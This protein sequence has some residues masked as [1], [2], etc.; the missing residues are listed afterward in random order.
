MADV[1][2]AFLTYY[3]QYDR[4]SAENAFAKLNSEFRFFTA[5]NTAPFDAEIRMKEE[6]IAVRL[7]FCEGYVAPE[8]MTVIGFFFEHFSYSKN[9]VWTT[10][11]QNI[12]L[13]FIYGLDEFR[14]YGGRIV[15]HISKSGVRK[16][17]DLLTEGISD[18]L[19]LKL[20][21]RFKM[22]EVCKWTEF[23]EQMNTELLA[24]TENER[25]DKIISMDVPVAENAYEND[26]RAAGVFAESAADGLALSVNNLGRVD[27]EYISKIT[28]ESLKDVLS[29]LSGAVYQNPASWGECFYKGWETADMY[30]SGNILEKLRTAKA[31]NAKYKG[32]FRDN[33]KALKRVLPPKISADDIYITLGSPWVPPD[34]IDDFILYLLGAPIS[35]YSRKKKKH[36]TEYDAEKALWKIPYKAE[37]KGQ[38]KSVST[39]GTERM[40][41]LFILE[42]TLNMR[43]VLVFDE[44]ESTESKSG[45]KR[46]I[47]KHETMLAAEK[48]QIMMKEFSN[49][50]WQDA[51]R[52]AR[53][54]DI[55]D[56]TFG[57]CVV[58]RYDGSFL[59]F[60]EM[61]ACNT[62]YDYQK[63]AVAR[64]MFSKNTLLAH[65][66]GAGKTYVMIAAG[67]E[68][69]RIGI[70]KKNMYVVPNSILG[71][72]K[73]IFKRL[74]PRA[75]VFCVEPDLFTPAKRDKTLL[76]MRDEDF[77]AILIAYSCFDRIPTFKQACDSNFT[78]CF[79]D[80]KINT[81]F[82]DEAH[83][84]KNL[85]FKTKITNVLGI[86]SAG[87]EKC[88]AM[89]DKVLTVQK[90]NHGRGV[91]FATGTPITNSLTDIYTMQTYL[92][93][94]ALARFGLQSFDS[95]VGMFAE[96]T[97]EAEIG[98]DTSSFRMATRFSKFHNLPELAMLI[99][100]FADF[101]SVDKQNE[102]PD[103]AGYTDD[104]VSKTKEMKAYLE[105]IS[106]RADAIRAHL[107]DS[108]T[109]NMLK[110]TTDGRKAALDIRLVDENAV[111]SAESKAMH[112][113]KN[114]MEIYNK[115]KS[116]KSVQLIFCDTSTPKSAFNMY[117]EM[118]RLLIMLGAEEK[119]IAY[120]HDAKNE[121]ERSTLFSKVQNGEVR[122]LIGS[123]F[124][125]GIGVN[126][127]NKLC[128][129]HHLDVPWRPAD[130]VQREGRILRRGNENKQ[131]QIFRYITEGS[132][133]AYSWQLLESK[134]KVIAGLLSGN[135]DR[136]SCEE[137]DGAVLDYAEVKALALGNPLLK[138]RVE[139]ANELARCVILQKKLT[140]T[141]AALKIEKLQL[142]DK[143]KRQQELLRKAT[144]DM[145]FIKNHSSAHDKEE[146]K[147]VSDSLFARLNQHEGQAKECAAMT[148]R[149][150]EIVLPAGMT[151]QKPFI[152]LVRNGRY[153]L[154]LGTSQKG[155][156]IRIDSFLDRFE[157]QTEKTVSG[158]TVLEEREKDIV[159]ELS[160][161][162]DYTEWIQK[163]KDEIDRIDREIGLNKKK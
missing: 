64:I 83:N 159:S 69:R 23:L 97:T 143:I 138:K 131:V 50:V 124:K 103:I 96:R 15:L 87:S 146:R 65:G 74:Y 77:D 51:A 28:G 136:R 137:I 14:S 123:T 13:F 144:A 112:C 162:G 91:V 108:E 35:S 8:L 88:S 130:V 98:V 75:E 38:I 11:Q 149:G 78:V 19:R 31:A 63:N 148:Y 53:L 62:L 82:V 39:Y 121:E 93:P 92:Q 139:C 101:Y 17:I 118:K 85:P 106:E 30:L 127:Q 160:K 37:Y 7:S 80:L 114:V 153:R 128:A 44:V 86:C 157:K 95:W 58:R 126:V 135:A 22:L 27:I 104:R 140:E 6:C 61:S 66:V 67:M 25:I 161:A 89:H 34:V 84:Y 47:N 16:V 111:F 10:K 41:A 147:S 33:V 158:L 56:K 152:Y 2:D 29:E 26:A 81:L 120:I 55:Y 52:K 68:M 70:S 90:Q 72:W 59:N 117:D 129:L 100:L 40:E 9:C 154:E 73:E 32:Y 42:K 3:N 141:R 60:P 134:Q 79:E 43:P 76:K 155:I 12:R 71:Q 46:V 150:F 156:L 125:L 132:F 107:V 113:A 45:K 99:G 110:L 5:Y 109:D 163:L 49:W 4:G 151:K 94:D 133:D 122:I 18:A 119:E 24:E 116:R 102:I 21:R 105:H 36:G 1:R 20:C 142:P 48:Q 115:T 57:A 145:N 54:E